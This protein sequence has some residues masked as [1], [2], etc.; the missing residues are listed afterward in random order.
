VPAT[1]VASLPPVPP[2]PVTPVQNW[3]PF[4]DVKPPPPNQKLQAR[5][6]R[7][8]LVAAS[9]MAASKCSSS[10][11]EVGSDRAEGGGRPESVPK[12]NSRVS[13]LGHCSFF[14]LVHA[15]F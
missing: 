12:F 4:T 2:R 11:A 9:M 1:P 13:M 5:L 14:C 6:E 8:A 10:N 15:R 7:S 3:H